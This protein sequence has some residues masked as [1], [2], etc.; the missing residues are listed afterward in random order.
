MRLCDV[1]PDG[2]STLITRGNMNLTA[3]DGRD[4]VVEFPAGQ[5]VDIT[6]P[7]TGIAYQVPAGHLLRL[8]VSTAYWP[9]IWPQAQNEP[10]SIDLSASCVVVPERP[11]HAQGSAQDLADKTVVFG[12]P[13][14]PPL[15]DVEYPEEGRS[16][17][18]RPERQISF[19]VAKQETM[20]QVDPMYGGT[21]V[22]PDGLRYNE[23]AVE[24]YWI[25]WDDPT[26]ARTE[27]QWRVEL[28]RPDLSWQ[29]SL[30]ADT[31]ICCDEKN[32]YT[33]SVVECFDADEKIF[34]KTWQETIPREAS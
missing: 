29:A 9:W 21:R 18:R 26:S 22:Y 31:R 32:F 14:Q 10:V 11:K 5:W 7:M 30:T 27:A 8:A 16:G 25:N 2:S 3:R 13:V 19:D 15:I 34:A 20:I 1:A 23:D 12:E 6:I 28:K 33:Q 4:K 24:R 17:A